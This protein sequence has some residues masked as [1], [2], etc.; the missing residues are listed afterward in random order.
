MF[1]QSVTFAARRL[2]VPGLIWLCLPVSAQQAIQFSTPV[3]DP[4]NQEI[5]FAP[6]TDH[7]VTSAFNAP[8]PLFRVGP[9]ASF[10]LLPSGPVPVIVTPR[11]QQ[12]QKNQDAMRNWTLLTPEQILGVPTPE[13]ILGIADPEEDPN[14]S[15]EERFLK[16]R[17]RQSEAGMEATN[18]WQPV[19]HS[20]D[21]L[22]S[23]P[24]EDSQ[25]ATLFTESLELSTS[26]S[27]GLGDKRDFKQLFSK[28]SMAGGNSQADSL[29]SSP[30]GSPA[31]PAKAT[32]EQ[33]AGM[34]RF[35]TLFMEHTEQE[36]P[37]TAYAGQA[38]ATPNPNFQV[39]PAFNSS[40]HSF[41]ALKD[42]IAKPMGLA[43]LPGITGPAPTPVKKTSSV[44][45]PPWMSSTA[46]HASLPQRQF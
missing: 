20:K 35:R 34:E 22:R 23:G 32:P 46:E 7:K 45:P 19:M 42:D 1:Y 27:T 28:D 3:E 13:S 5:A 15:L 10:N 2:V 6:K 18:I 9:S 30:F 37:A 4:A 31:A 26:A 39:Q 8:K 24:F 16:R 41:A 25:T 43:P 11:N 21:G 29:W 36:K 44:Q 12:W 14:Q 17:E 38:T 33:L 40:G